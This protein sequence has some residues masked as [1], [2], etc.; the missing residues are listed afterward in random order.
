MENTKKQFRVTKK[1]NFAKY[2]PY[3]IFKRKSETT[4]GLKGNEYI[5]DYLFCSQF[6]D[7]LN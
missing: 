2:H 7:L 4:F 5:V 6:N 3:I 1:E